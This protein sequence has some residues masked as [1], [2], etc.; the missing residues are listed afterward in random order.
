MNIESQEWLAYNDC[1][2]NPWNIMSN[3]Y[4]QI[5]R[6]KDTTFLQVEDFENISYLHV[7]AKI[8]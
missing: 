5:W 1:C 7:A 3:L 2:W 4:Q 8:A 6:P